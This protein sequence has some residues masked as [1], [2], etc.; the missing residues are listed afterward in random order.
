[1][2]PVKCK[3]N[4]SRVCQLLVDKGRV[5]LRAVL[6]AIHPPSTLV[7]VLSAHKSV[8][9]KLRYSVINGSQWNLLYPVSGT[10]DSRNFDITLLTILLRNICGLSSP[11]T[12]WNIMPSVSDTSISA[13]IAKIKIFRNEVYGH[14]P[15]AQLDDT[16][17]ET[18]W[19]EIS[20]PLVKLGIPQ[21]D[22]DELKVAPFSSEEE[23]YIEKL[24]EWKDL[25]DDFLSKFNGLEG[26]DFELGKIIKYPVPSNVD[27]LTKFVFTEKI[28]FLCKEFRDGTKQRFFENLTSWFSDRQ[29][30]VMILT[31]D[32]GVGKSVLC[33][34]ICELYKQRGQLA[35]C[36][37][38]DIKNTDCGNLHKIL[39][40]LASQMCENVEGFRENLTKA[41]RREHSRDS[42]SDAFR[43]LLNDPL[44]GLDRC[45]PMLI[46][47]DFWNDIKN[48]DE[49]ELLGMISDDFFHLPKWV[50]V[51]VGSKEGK[52][53]RKKLLHLQ[54]GISFWDE[55]NVQ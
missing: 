51:L 20:K 6:L 32:P 1:M 30:R 10:P 4:Y 27:Q 14:T 8:L 16:T 13:N 41:L 39:H 21:Q 26:G 50:K 38:C 52:S 15:T 37:F 25:E 11:A 3:A 35:A 42:V 43:V 12:G 29:S 55:G 34:K 48:D 23:S 19:Q 40:S 45:E 53:A 33:A 7:A 36:H 9:K 47:L 22:I 2:D 28:K 31:A 44:H 54:S 17:F 24:K 18:L 46:V 49:S 5:A